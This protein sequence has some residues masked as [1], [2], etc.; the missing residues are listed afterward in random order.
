MILSIYKNKKVVYI[1]T[2]LGNSY[3]TARSIKKLNKN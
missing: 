3:Y 2:N 1:N